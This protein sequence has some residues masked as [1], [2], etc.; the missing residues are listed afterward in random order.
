M[1]F[2]RVFCMPDHQTFRMSP[3]RDLLHRYVAAGQVWADPFAGWNSPASLTNDLNPSTPAEFHMDAE[4]FVRQRCPDVLDGALFDPPYSPRQIAEV[5]KSVGLAV[6]LEETQNGRLYKRVKD[7][8][9]PKIR[10]GGHVIC[11]GWN[12]MGMGINRGYELIEVLLVPHG[13][14]HNDTIVTVERKTQGHLL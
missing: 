1:L 7:A 4:L 2:E 10:A 14:A 11:C 3:V 5:Y 12:S 6:G 8:L 9:H 13:G